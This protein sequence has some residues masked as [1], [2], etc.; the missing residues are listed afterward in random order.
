MV[1]KLMLDL[2]FLKNSFE[3]IFKHPHLKETPWFLTLGN[4]DYRGYTKKGNPQAQ[5]DYTFV[6]KRWYT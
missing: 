4:H 3:A 6:S 5:V 2:L 1:S